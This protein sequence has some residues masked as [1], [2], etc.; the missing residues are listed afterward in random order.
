MSWSPPAARWSAARI[1]GRA[2]CPR[3]STSRF[4][5]WSCSRR[6]TTRPRCHSPRGDPGRGRRAPLTTEPFRAVVLLEAGDD[7]AAMRLLAWGPRAWAARAD[8]DE[9]AAALFRR[10]EEHTS[11]LQSRFGIS[12]G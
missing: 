8:A 12:Y 5:P 1:T 11:E 3:S 6:A 9:L 10:S 4:G 2:G 7:A